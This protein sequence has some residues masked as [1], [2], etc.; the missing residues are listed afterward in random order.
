MGPPCSPPTSW[1]TY[2]PPLASLSKLRTISFTSFFTG[3]SIL[4][5]KRRYAGGN[6]WHRGKRRLWPSMTRLPSFSPHAPSHA[7]GTLRL[8]NF[9][10][11]MTS[12]T[13]Q[14]VSLPHRHLMASCRP[15]LCVTH[16]SNCFM[17]R[18]RAYAVAS[19]ITACHRSALP[20]VKCIIRQDL[21]PPHERLPIGLNSQR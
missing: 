3:L 17:R 6:D 18:I 5:Q 21:S 15:S 13:A 7:R 12:R 1:V 10:S 14:D 19:L 11:H 20:P 2:S 4:G 16:N 9:T 8:T